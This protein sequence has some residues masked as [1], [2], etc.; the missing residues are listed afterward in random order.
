MSDSVECGVTHEVVI[1]GEK[2]WVRYAVNSQVRDG[3]TVEEARER[4]SREVNTGVLDVIR[5]T[6]ETVRKASH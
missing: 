2:S 5:Q 4:V 3:E 6:V 1:D